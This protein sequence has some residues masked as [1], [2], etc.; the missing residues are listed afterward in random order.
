MKTSS[1]IFHVLEEGCMIYFRN[2]GPSPVKEGTNNVTYP[3]GKNV[4]DIDSTNYYPDGKR[5]KTHSRYKIMDI[6][7]IYIQDKDGKFFKFVDHP[8]QNMKYIEENVDAGCKARV[9]KTVVGELI[10]KLPPEKVAQINDWRIKAFK[11]LHKNGIID[12]EVLE[13]A[14]RTSYRLHEI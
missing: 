6:D 2:A 7:I 14:N 8:P 3:N 12:D 10:E 5:K 4:V 13:R 11:A 1:N 9:K